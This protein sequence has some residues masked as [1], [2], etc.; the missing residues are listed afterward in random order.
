M[1]SHVS[2][3]FALLSAASAA[4]NAVCVGIAL[5]ESTVM[6]VTIVSIVL[7]FVTLGTVAALTGPIDRAIVPPALIFLVAG[8]F[9]PALYRL[10]FYKSIDLIGVARASTIAN[11]SPIFSSI[12]AVHLLRESLSWPVAVG[13]IVVVIGIAL[14]MRSKEHGHTRQYWVGVTMSSISALMASIS[15]II[16]KIGLRILPDPTLAAMLTAAGGLLTLL[17]Y[18]VLRYHQDPLRANG[19]SLAYLI[20]GSL[21]SACSFLAYNIALNQGEV[22]RVGPLNNTAPV[23][24]LGMLYVFR[25]IETVALRTAMGVIVTVVGSLLVIMG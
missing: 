12:L 15:L 17:P 1:S 6:T 11:T 22:V 10:T 8:I 9:A 24:A 19:T 25:H 5:R 7:N 4:G 16:G 13:T 3:F 21:L 18:T 2:D 23:F 20:A 14:M